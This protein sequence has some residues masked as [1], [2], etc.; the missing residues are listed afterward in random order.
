MSSLFVQ[1]TVVPTGTVSVCGPKTKLSI[2]TAAFTADGRSLLLALTLGDP[3]NSSSIAIISGVATP[4]TFI[5]L[6]VILCF[7]S[8]FLFL[9][10]LVCSTDRLQPYGHPFEIFSGVIHVLIELC[11]RGSEKDLLNVWLFPKLLSEG[12]PCAPCFS[13]G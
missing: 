10:D 2:L 8:V 1:V 11:G 13:I 3:A 4:T 9:P 6:F 5:L 7:L 12:F